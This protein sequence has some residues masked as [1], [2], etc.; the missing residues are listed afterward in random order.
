VVVN[1]VA[2]MVHAFDLRRGQAWGRKEVRATTASA[3]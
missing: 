3:V 2:E 1:G